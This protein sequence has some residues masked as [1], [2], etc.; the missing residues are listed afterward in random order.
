MRARL[1]AVGAGP[2]D[3]ELITVRGLRLLREAETVFFPATREGASFAQQII[4]GYL[5]PERQ[6]L[7]ELLCPP[8]REQALLKRRWLELAAV[9]RETLAN[10]KSGVFVCEG[11][12][13]LYSTFY[14]LREG[15][16]QAAPE[17]LIDIV[18]GVNAVS[19]SAAVA[20]LPLAIWDERLLIA[21][22]PADPD[23]LRRYFSDAETLALLKVGANFD[24]VL[25]A[26]KQV[27]ARSIMVRRAGRPE[28]QVLVDADAMR[29]AG[30]DYF[31]T[32]LVKKG[33]G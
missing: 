3:P 31:T 20:G 10:R 11:D 14:Y 17:I 13:S 28:Q 25:K 12:P 24:P 26:I 29:D 7:V 30:I 33:E 9:V 6:Q 18:P 19:A 5:D 16:E 23:T 4:S 27:G 8:Y 21:P 22:A 15:L 1:A 2:G 32:L